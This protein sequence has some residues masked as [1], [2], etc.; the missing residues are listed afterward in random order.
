MVKLF[1]QVIIGAVSTV[2]VGLLFMRLSL[3]AVPA[4]IIAA[5]IISASWW[6]LRLKL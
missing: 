5:A 2:A 4:M 6:I 1:V 3:D